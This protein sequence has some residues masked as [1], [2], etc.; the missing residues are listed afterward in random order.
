MK[1]RLLPLI[2]LAVMAV[3]L[4]FLYRKVDF[5]EFGSALADFHWGWLPLIYAMFLVNSGISALKWKLLLASDGVRVPFFSLLSSYLIG[6]FFNMFLPSSIGGD[7]YRVV[8]TSR[9]GGGA[10]SFASVFADRL[11]GFLALAS[12]GLL[13]SAIGWAQL[14]DKRIL[15]LPVV[16]FGIMAAMVFA[17]VQRRML[18]AVLRLL[19]IDRIPKIDG[20]IHKVLDSVAAYGSSRALLAKVFA[21]S[22]SFQMLAITIIFCISPGDAVGG[23]LYL[24]QHLRAADHPGRGHAH[25]HFRH[26]RARR[27]VFVLL[28]AGRG[29]P[30]NRRWPWRWSTCS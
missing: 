27:P 11:S 4:A 24:L 7:A 20:F 17:I 13:F 21:I 18:V 1:K 3:L 28:H 23:A 29:P 9:H 6:S 30:T 25:L 5:A 16:V 15:W 8:E 26:R 14:P 2:K 12:W 10:K 19:R 22:L